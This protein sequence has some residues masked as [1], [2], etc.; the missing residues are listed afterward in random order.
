MYMKQLFAMF[1][2]AVAMPLVAGAQVRLSVDEQSVQ[3]AGGKKMTIYLY[4]QVV[5]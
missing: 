5:I 1:L 2:L 4:L 3:A